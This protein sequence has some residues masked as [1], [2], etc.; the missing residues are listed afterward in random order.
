[1]VFVIKFAVVKN[2]LLF[3]F[4]PRFGFRAAL[5]VQSNFSEVIAVIKTSTFSSL[6]L[7]GVIITLILVEKKKRCGKLCFIS[8]QSPARLR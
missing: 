8:A 3:L 7:H 6:Y 2:I 5:A 4:F 1:M